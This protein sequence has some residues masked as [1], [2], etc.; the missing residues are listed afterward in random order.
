MLKNPLGALGLPHLIILDL[1]L[2][3]MDG[4]QVLLRLKTDPALRKI[5]VVVLSSSRDPKDVVGSYNNY[6]NC[7][8]PKPLSFEDYVSVAK[9]I[10]EFWLRVVSLPNPSRWAA[11]PG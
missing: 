11:A 7:Y 2:P 6:A 1:N 3:K 4:K 5:P 9:G 10:Q 8:I